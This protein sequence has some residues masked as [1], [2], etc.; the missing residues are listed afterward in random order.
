[1][2]NPIRTFRDAKSLTLQQFGEMVGLR[3]ALVWKYENG[4]LRVPAELVPKIEQA[5]GIP[6]HELRPDLWPREAA[7]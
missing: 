3:K 1:M 5:T 7:E 6:R 4:R 2:M